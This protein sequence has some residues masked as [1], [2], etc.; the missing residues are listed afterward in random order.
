MDQYLYLFIDLACISIPFVASFHP[1]LNFYKEWKAYFPAM[2]LVALF[3]LLWDEWFTRAGIWGFNDQYI[4]GIKAGQLP[5]EEILFFI[6]IPYACVF[7][8]FSVKKL[9]INFPLKGQKQPIGFALLVFSFLVAALY[10]NKLYTFITFLLLAITIGFTYYLN[11]WEHLPAIFFSYLLILPFF[12]ISNGL[13]TGFGIEE[14]VVWYNNSENI[15][16]RI[17]T[18]PFEDAFYGFL[19]IVM[20]TELYEAIKK[21]WF[22]PS[23]EK[24]ILSDY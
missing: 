16:R 6:C 10:F 13:L 21:R 15:G 17:A 9:W 1:K 23:S 11:R 24:H 5:L 18:I 2:I 20:N 4:T 22:V 8:Y 14:E 19:L 7:T 12:F 3:F